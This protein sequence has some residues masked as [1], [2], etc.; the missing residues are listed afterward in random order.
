MRGAKHCARCG[1]DANTE[2]VELEPSRITLEPICRRCYLGLVPLWPGAVGAGLTDPY[3]RVYY[4][5]PAG[6]D[7][8]EIRWTT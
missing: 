6:R 2:G 3:G 7:V 4:I 1:V 8:K 5:A